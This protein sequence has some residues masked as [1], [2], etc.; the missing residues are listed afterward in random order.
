MEAIFHGHSFVELFFE[1][2]RILIDPFIIGNPLCDVTEEYYDNKQ[3]DGIIVTH[4]HDDHIGST[5]AL[6]KKHECVVITSY[7]LGKYFENELKIDKVSTHWIWWRVQYDWFCVKFVLA[8]HG[9]GISDF[10]H[11]YTTVAAWVVVTTEKNSVY[12]AWDTGLYSDMNLLCDKNIDVAFLP[13]WDR[14]TMWVEDAVTAASLIKAKYT[15]PMHY[16]TRDKIKVNDLEFARLV[17]LSNMSVP[18]VLRPGQWIV[19]ES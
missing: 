1:N 11:W 8:L 7:E 3:I 6:A 12:H 14:Y 18:K 13:I 5:Q 16:N 15:V 10:T 2:K 4:G 9:W 19:L 17:M